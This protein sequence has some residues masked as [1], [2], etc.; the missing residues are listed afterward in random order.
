MSYAG[1]YSLLS[2]HLA[3]SSAW[4]DDRFKRGLV[5]SLVVH[6]VLLLGLMSVR[7]S[8][9]IQQPL[10]S[11]RVNLV[12]LQES[13]APAP[14]KKTTPIKKAKI[15]QSTTPAPS[16]ETTPVQKTK[17][18]PEAA[19]PKPKIDPVPPPIVEPVRTEQVTQSI[20]DA[21]ESVAVPQSRDMASVPNTPVIAPTATES[22]REPIEEQSITMPVIPQAPKISV[23]QPSPKDDPPAP[24]VPSPGSLADTLKQAVQSVAVPQNPQRPPAQI[25]P[26]PNSKSEN[27]ASSSQSSKVEPQPKVPSRPRVADS[28]KQVLQSV[29]VP[30]MKQSSGAPKKNVQAVP[31]PNPSHQEP[32]LQPRKELEGIVMPSEAPQLA[33]VDRSKIQALLKNASREHSPNS[34]HENAVNQKIAKLMIPDVQAPEPHHIFSK[35]VES[36]TQ[37]ATT[38]LQVSGSSPEGHPYWGRVWS[39]IDREWVAPTVQVS[40]LNPLRVVLAFRIE[41]N[42]AVKKLAIEQSSGNEYYDIAAKRAVLDAAPL[43][44]F[45]PDMREAYYDVQFQFT[46]NVDS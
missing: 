34:V 13:T 15:S 45:S 1:H 25:K 22:V 29:V 12:T 2:G 41:R 32:P 27:L 28:L 11:Y 39:K 35:P 3:E 17:T 19:T 7:F 10:A 8:P 44:K 21:L 40:S 4:V 42:G 33:A 9:T 16:K 20:V 46:V 26:S 37:N 18:P 43:P 6:A 38:T 14:L 36:G 23:Q 30:E 24:S 31:V 5:A